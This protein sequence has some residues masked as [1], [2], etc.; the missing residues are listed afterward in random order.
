MRTIIYFLFGFLVGVL[1]FKTDLTE[2]F[3]RDIENSEL[4]KNECVQEIIEK[5]KVES[6][7][8]YEEFK[9]NFYK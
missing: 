6:W 1:V 2:L 7:N 5:G 8:L 4:G 9:N 3:A